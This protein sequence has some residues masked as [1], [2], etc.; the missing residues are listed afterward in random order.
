MRVIAHLSDLHFGRVDEDLVGPLLSKLRELN[1]HLVAVSGD[2]TQRAKSREFLAARRFLDALSLPYLVVP[3]NHDIPAYNLLARF[4]LKFN[5]YGRYVTSD[6]FPYYEN[7]EIAVL[8]LN[9]A[10]AFALKGGRINAAQVSYMREK[11]CRLPENVIK[12]V[13][14]HHPFDVPENL[15]DDLIVGRSRAAMQ[16]FAACGADVFLSGHL[17]VT[18]SLGTHLRYRIKGHSALVV[19]AGTAISS[20]LRGGETNAFNVLKIENAWIQVLRFGWIR[21]ESRFCEDRAELF[22]HTDRG[23]ILARTTPP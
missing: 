8:G 4:F 7:G 13:V 2:L 14:T 1:P 6:M 10:R 18:H 17:H 3:G 12:I 11:F 16:V 9:T 15:D 19:Q 21:N 5:K 20:R 23:W 22:E